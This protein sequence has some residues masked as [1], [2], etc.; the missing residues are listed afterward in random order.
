MTKDYGS[1]EIGGCPQ[2]CQQFGLVN[3]GEKKVGGHGRAVTVSSAV[4]GVCV[5]VWRYCTYCTG[6]TAGLR[7]CQRALRGVKS[8]GRFRARV[9]GRAGRAGT[10]GRAVCHIQALQ[11]CAAA[12]LVRSEGDAT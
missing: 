7:L 6:C 12:E 2:G 9:A 5:C 11:R 10:Q 8:Q 4:E 3:E 1:Y